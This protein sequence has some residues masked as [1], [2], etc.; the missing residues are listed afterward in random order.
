MIIR[1]DVELE[2]PEG[3]LHIVEAE[4]RFH[5]GVLEDWYLDTALPVSEKFT[6]YVIQKLYDEYRG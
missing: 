4:G 3:E 6:E 2:T 1:I 5:T